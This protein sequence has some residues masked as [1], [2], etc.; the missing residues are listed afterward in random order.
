MFFWRCGQFLK[1][2]GAV[3]LT[4]TMLLLVW[5]S[6][7][8]RFPDLQG[9]RRFY[10]GSTSSQATEKDRLDIADLPLVRG[11]SISLVGGE[12]LAAE[13]MEK[14]GAKLLFCEETADVVSYYC[15]SARW[16]DGVVVQG[17]FVNLHIA[18]SEERCV[19]GSPLI[20]GS[21]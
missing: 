5:S 20:F 9:E 15:Y 2:A 11:E 3:L 1:S 6:S 10:L 13:L 17:Q 8:L 16:T 19:V 21:F 18:L 4:A 12:T 14:Y 7:L